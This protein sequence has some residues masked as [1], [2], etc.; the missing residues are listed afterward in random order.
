MA[1]ICPTVTAENE[2]Q[3]RDQVERLTA[4]ATR[5]HIDF[6][7]GELTQTRSPDVGKAWWPHTMQADLHLMYQNPWPYLEAIVPLHPRLVIVHAEV[8]AEG[9]NLNEFLNFAGALHQAGIQVGIALLAKTSSKVIL[10]ML[11][12]LDHVL[13]FSGSLG[14]FGGVADLDLLAK[15]AEVKKMKSDLE[16]GWDGGITTDNVAALVAGGVDVL[17]VGGFIQRSDDPAAAYKELQKLLQ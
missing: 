5:V 8:V 13:I 10:P 4:F 3:Y 14:Q 15:V 16:V 2:H 6:M 1:V 12:V 11:A 7:D 9:D 17:N